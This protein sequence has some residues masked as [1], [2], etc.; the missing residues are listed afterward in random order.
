M[1]VLD[2]VV[3]ADLFPADG[4]SGGAQIVAQAGSNGGY[5]A[6]TG[7]D[8][9]MQLGFMPDG[10]TLQW[11]PQVHVGP[12]NIILEKG[13]RGIRFRNYTAGVVATV[14][15][16]ISEPSEPA[17]QLTSA[18]VSSSTSTGGGGVILDRVVNLT[19]FA[20]S[21]AENTLYD[22][23]LKA[24]TLPNSGA[25]RLTL[26]GRWN[27]Q[28]AGAN[29][30]TWKI[31]FGGVTLWGA[32]SNGFA[33]A[34]S[35]VGAWWLEVLLMNCGAPNIQSIGAAGGMSRDT[36]LAGGGA[37][38]GPDGASE[39]LAAVGDIADAAIDTTADQH[40]TVTCQQ[41]N[42]NVGNVIA[43]RSGILEQL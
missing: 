16:G 12:G 33:G 17:I 22:Y 41:S 7:A 28:S 31:K 4:S 43:V 29:T 11:T 6:V 38:A 40:L 20:N 25:L 10:A 32:A 21:L 23:L 3:C 18:G 2:S 34:G 27:S 1:F 9:Y 26:R 42:A 35:P 36:P 13:T 39:R 30:F 24:G 19:S 15:A 5:A 8:V 14:S 37:I